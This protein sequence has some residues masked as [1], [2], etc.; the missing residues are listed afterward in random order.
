MLKLYLK[1]GK[2][3]ETRPSD[4][5]QTTPSKTHNTNSQQKQTETQTKQLQTEKQEHKAPIKTIN[6]KITNKK[7]IHEN[8]RN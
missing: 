7:N 8:N 2:T 1:R 3:A 5:R 4:H 6:W